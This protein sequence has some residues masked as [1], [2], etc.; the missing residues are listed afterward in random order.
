VLTAVEL[1][2]GTPEITAGAVAF[3]IEIGRYRDAVD[4]LHRALGDPAVREPHKIY[5][6]LWVL[7]EA[8]RLGEPPDRLA[9]EYLASRRGELWYE[10]LA[11]AATGRLSFEALRAAATTG[12]QRG[13][14][15]FYGAVLGVDP[16]ATTPAGWRR[17]LQQVVSSRVVLDAEYDLARAYLAPAQAPIADMEGHAPPGPR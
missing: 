6:S 13:E 8:R 3:L 2:P 7:G 5:P 1:D 14:L 9:H 16:E 10:R 15:A 12:P 17:L 11:Q 4:A